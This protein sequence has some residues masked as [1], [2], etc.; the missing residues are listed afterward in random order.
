MVKKSSPKRGSMAFSPRVRAKHIDGRTRTWPEVEGEPRL[1]GFVGYK[2]GMTHVFMIEDR[3]KSPD[4]GREVHRAVTVLDTPPM[5]ICAIRVYTKTPDGL[6]VLSEAWAR[7]LPKDLER[8][9]LKTVRPDCDEALKRIEES[10]DEVCEV[11][12]IAA[13]QPRLA[14]VPKKKPEL[15][16]IKIGGGTVKEQFEYAKSILGKEVRVSEVFKEGQA[17]DITAVTKGKGFQGP[18]KRWG[19]KILPR[20]SRKTKRGVGSIGPWHPARVMPTVPRAGQMGFHQRTEYDK[21]IVKIGS[22]GSE[23][24]PKGGFHKYGVI[25]GDYVMVLGSVPGPQKRLIRMRVAVRRP[26]FPEAPPQITYV[27]TQ[28][29]PS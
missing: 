3:E 24:T 20:K 13:T 23:I 18:V 29:T 17:V 28:F 4:Y 1:L 2:A 8:L 10:L 27:D 25:K 5:V 16:E 21:R 22:N 7:E 26:R 9:H 6:K 11:R 12:V 14:S 19:I 15:I